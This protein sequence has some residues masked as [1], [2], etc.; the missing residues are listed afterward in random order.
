MRPC[1]HSRLLAAS[2]AP[3]APAAQHSREKGWRSLYAGLKPSVV[4]T[5]TSQGI[6]F[7]VYSML[8]GWAVVGVEVL[9]EGGRSAA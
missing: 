6:Y 1:R 4:A 3:L 8:R 7:Y 2:H 5:A 9:W